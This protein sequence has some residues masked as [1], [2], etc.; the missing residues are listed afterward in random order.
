MILKTTKKITSITVL[1]RR[2]SRYTKIKSNRMRKSIKTNFWQIKSSG[3]T[4]WKIEKLFT[5]NLISSYLMNL[6]VAELLILRKTF[7]IYLIIFLHIYLKKN[8]I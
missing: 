4:I 1:M 8:M 5:L 6:E 7:T 3:L 2:L